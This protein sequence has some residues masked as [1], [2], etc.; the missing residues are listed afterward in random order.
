[1]QT[2]V[3]SIMYMCV[4]VPACVCVCVCVYIRLCVCVCFCAFVRV[5]TFARECSAP[6]RDH[7]PLFGTDLRHWVLGN[8]TTVLK[9]KYGLGLS[10]MRSFHK[11][12]CRL[13]EWKIILEI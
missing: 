9:V 13:S 4:C 11:H 5:D 3:H 6:N 8:H 7:L 12:L 2:L 10:K 1:M